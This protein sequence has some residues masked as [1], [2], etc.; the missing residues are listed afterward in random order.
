MKSEYITQAE[1]DIIG[2]W[3]DII[4]EWPLWSRWT[5]EK[6]EKQES[7]IRRIRKKL[8]QMAA[9]GSSAAFCVLAVKLF[10]AVHQLRWR[11]YAN[12]KRILILAP[13]DHG[14]SMCFAQWLPLEEIAR[15]PNIRILLVRKTLDNIRQIIKTII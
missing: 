14:K 6:L 12:R 2:L 15:N 11:E 10:P 5:G 8:F 3:K 4:D 7:L 9:D 1:L 13:R